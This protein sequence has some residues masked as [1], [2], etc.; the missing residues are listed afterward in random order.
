MPQVPRPASKSCRGEAVRRVPPGENGAE[1]G[2]EAVM[3][4]LWPR[5]W[6]QDGLRGYPAAGVNVAYTLRWSVF[7]DCTIYTI[8]GGYRDHILLTH[9]VPHRLPLGVGIVL[10]RY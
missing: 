9:V 5:R 10:K 8:S 7:H 4:L 3:E 6:Q 2:E 1:Q